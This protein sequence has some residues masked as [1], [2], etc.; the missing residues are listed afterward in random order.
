MFQYTSTISIV[1]PVK[2]KKQTSVFILLTIIS[3]E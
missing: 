2:Q 1:E 3:I